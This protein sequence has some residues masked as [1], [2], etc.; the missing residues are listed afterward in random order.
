MVFI[1][2]K[3]Q[4]PGTYLTG[5]QKITGISEPDMSVLGSMGNTFSPVGGLTSA[6]QEQAS[7]YGF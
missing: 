3:R 2:S 6:E 7:S 1:K 4:K 5:N